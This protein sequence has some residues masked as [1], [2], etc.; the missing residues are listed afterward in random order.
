MAKDGQPASSPRRDSVIARHP[1]P[2][3]PLT[4]TAPRANLS[5]TVFRLVTFG[6][7]GI[8]GDDGAAAPRLR[9]PRLA[10]LA[11]LAAAGH[12]GMSREKLTALF[13]PDADEE[14]A[15]HSLRQNLY[16]L[17]T[18]LGRDVVRSVG[19]TLTLDETTISAD[20]TDFRVALAAGDREQAVLL[21]RGAFLDG[22]Y[23]QGTSGFE[24]WV[25]E[26][27]GRLTA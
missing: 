24:R 3:P 12:R 10:L 5:F 9:A 13:W 21:A 8:E 6:G 4:G 22:F 19:Q 2:G 25:E 16:A 7:L 14:R 1:C 15:R 27:R 26:E 17:R 18:G 23:L 11:V 20:V